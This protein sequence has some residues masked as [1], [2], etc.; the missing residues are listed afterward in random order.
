[1]KTYISLLRGVNVTGYNLVKM[2]VLRSLYEKN[3]LVNPVSYLQSGN[4]LF[5]C[6][7]S[8]ENE[9]EDKI[10]SVIENQLDL[11]IQV[12]V[13]EMTRF[14]NIILENPFLKDKEKNPDFF[15]VTFLGED[16]QEIDT[17][18]ISNKKLEAEEFIISGRAVFLY[19]PSGY[20]KSK[21]SNNYFESLLKVKATTR[22]WRTCGEILKIGKSRKS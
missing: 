22:N 16:P 14:E 2:D 5:S 10:H 4:I 13:L 17:S 15:Y 6:E 1:M 20:G 18:K 19:C 7:G 11:K 12:I 3:G 21:L 9:L 8:P